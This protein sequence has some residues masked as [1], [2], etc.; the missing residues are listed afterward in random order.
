[1]GLVIV[2]LSDVVPLAGMFPEP[3]TFE[4]V[5]GATAATVRVAVAVKPVP[6]STEVTAFVVLT[7]VPAVFPVTLTLKVQEPLAG[8][9]PP[10]RIKLPLPATAVNVPAPQLPVRPFGV[11]ITTPAGNVSLKPTPVN[12]VEAFG[13]VMVKLSVLVPPTAML[14]GAKDLVIVGAAMPATVRVAVAVKPVPPSVEL[15]VP[16]VLTFVPAVVPVT[17]TLKVQEPLAAIVPPLRL[18]LPEPATAVIVPAPQLPVRPFGVETTTP[19][20]SVSV[21]ATPVKALAFGLVM[22]K[23]SVLVPPTT[24]LV[25]AKDLVIV[26]G[27]MPAATVTVA[28]AVQMQVPP[29]SELTG[30]VTL[31]FTPD[32]VPVTFTLKMQLLLAAIDPP[33]S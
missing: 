20:G 6:P 9:V 21:T 12:A 33:P 5:G 1:L 32:V 23:L 7:F 14:V 17:L 25:G 15:T 3:K 24:M 16:V 10:L 26:G 31:F 29:S 28:E 27:A 13:L 30:L 18:T 2:K 8:I 11:E 19:A 4:I 22:V